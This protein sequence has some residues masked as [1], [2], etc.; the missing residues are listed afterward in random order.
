MWLL[1][2]TTR[3]QNGRAADDVWSVHSTQ[4]EA[5]EAL[6]RAQFNNDND[7]YCWAVAPILHGSEPQYTDHG[8]PRE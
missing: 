6:D 1:A 4:A 7:L 2:Y 3:D 5:L 8:D